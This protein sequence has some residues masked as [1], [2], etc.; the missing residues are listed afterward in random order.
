[1]LF[2]RPPHPPKLTPQSTSISINNRP[3]PNL[4]PTISINTLNT[5]LPHQQRL[6]ININTLVCAPRHTKRLMKEP[7]MHI[8]RLDDPIPRFPMQITMRKLIESF[9]IPE[10]INHHQRV[11]RAPFATAPR[12]HT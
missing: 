7:N 10:V 6:T 2:E 4:L 11:V 3:N 5:S 1:M 12:R 8:P 9:H